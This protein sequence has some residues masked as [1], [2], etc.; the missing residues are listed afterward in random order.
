MKKVKFS[1]GIHEV[2]GIAIHFVDK[3]EYTEINLLILCFIFSLKFEKKKEVL[4]NRL[5][6]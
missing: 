4:T 2:L 5:K 3:K 1:I 6:S